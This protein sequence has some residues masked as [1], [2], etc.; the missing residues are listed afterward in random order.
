MSGDDLAIFL[1]FLTCAVAFGVEA[2]KAETATRRISFG[3][4]ALG[5][6]LSGIF[7]AHIKTVWPALTDKIATVATEPVSWF[8]II[9]FLPAVVAFHR[10]NPSRTK[11]SA[12]LRAR[13]RVP[14][15]PQRHLRPSLC[16]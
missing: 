5:C 1:F 9:M 13:C 15:C 12:P 10:L 4:I 14:H 3:V 7:W 16:H 2:V 6:L 8:V 11:R